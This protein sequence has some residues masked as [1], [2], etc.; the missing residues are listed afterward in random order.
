MKLLLY[1]YTVLELTLKPSSSSQ[2]SN[3]Q[4]PLHLY[5]LYSHS[6]SPFQRAKT[7]GPVLHPK[8]PYVH[9]AGTNL[10][11]R[12]AQL[13]WVLTKSSEFG[14]ASGGELRSGESIEGQRRQEDYHFLAQAIVW[15]FCYSFQRPWSVGD[16][17]M[18]AQRLCHGQ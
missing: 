17:K 5:P 7:A 13:I 18:R 6:I 2:N 14:A 12:S 8:D 10:Q 11:P 4:L 15:P 16:R 3:L 9:V 1:H